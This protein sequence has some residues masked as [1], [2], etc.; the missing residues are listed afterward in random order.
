MVIVGVILKWNDVWDAFNFGILTNV[1]WCFLW[2]QWI[3]V[4]QWFQYYVLLIAET[5]QALALN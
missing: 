5:K 4:N 3:V 2:K 1:V